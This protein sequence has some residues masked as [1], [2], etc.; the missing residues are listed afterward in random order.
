MEKWIKAIFTTCT[1]AARI[2]YQ[3]RLEN[4]EAN[5]EA[6]E[7][8]GLPPLAPVQ[9]PPRFDNLPSLSYIDSEDEEEEEQ[10]QLELDPHMRLSSSLQSIRRSTRRERHTS[11]TH[12]QGRVVVSSSFDNDDDSGGE[13]DVAGA[14][15]AVRHSPL[16]VDVPESSRSRPCKEKK[17]EKFGKWIK[18]III[19][20]TYTARTAYEDR[21]ENREANREARERAGLPPLSL[22]Q[23]PPR[24]DNLRSLSDTNSE[25]NDEEEE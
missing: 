4:H 1:Y 3:D 24:F 19:T 15:R 13:E 5:R 18:A 22:V 6:R 25:A 23:S 20:C 17:M 10:E 16:V 21:L 9:S 7:R 11:T 14:S 8:A 12:R 2:A